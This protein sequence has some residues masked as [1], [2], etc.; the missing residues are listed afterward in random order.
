VKTK[1]R[2]AP[3]RISFY[4]DV[5]R[6]HQIIGGPTGDVLEHFSKV[7]HHKLWSDLFLR[8]LC[9]A[10]E[11]TI[12]LARVNLLLQ[13]LDSAG[14]P[15]GSHA[16]A[17]QAFPFQEV[18]LV[19]PGSHFRGFKRSRFFTPSRLELRESVNK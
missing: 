8:F 16:H 5:V 4:L 15:V 13:R 10:L 18:D 7:F 14:Q 6:V 2:W 3:Y 9:L 1:L 11:T 19:G 17:S 12:L